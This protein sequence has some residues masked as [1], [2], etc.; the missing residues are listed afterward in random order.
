MEQF[1]QIILERNLPDHIKYDIIDRHGSHKAKKS[2]EEKN[3][4]SIQDSYEYVNIIPDFIPAGN[5]KYN[6]VELSFGYSDKY[7]DDHSSPYNN[8]SGWSKEDETKIIKEAIE[9]ITFEMVRSWFQ[10]TWTEMFPDRP[11]PL[12]LDP[13][14]K[15]NL[16]EREIKRQV[17]WFTKQTK[18][19]NKSSRGRTRIQKKK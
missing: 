19:K 17:D 3:E 4:F 5:P 12:Y 16:F 6:P 2:N 8:G 7:L 13:D 14:T 11:L 15:K 18:T 1:I 9:S 10:R